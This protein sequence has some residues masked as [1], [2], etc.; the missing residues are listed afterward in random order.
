[1]RRPNTLTRWLR[2]LGSAAG[3]RAAAFPAGHFYSPVVDVGDVASRAA[4]IWPPQPVVQGIDF[5]DGSHRRVLE[6]VFPKFMGDFDYP[7][8]L[9][10]GSAPTQF[11]TA[12]DQFGWLDARALFVLLR[13]WRPRRLIEVG[14]G[15]SSLLIADINRRWFDCAMTFI[16]IE[17]YPPAFLKAPV[18][19]ISRLIASQVQSLSLAEFT[20]LEAGDVL[21]ID[22]SHVSKTGSDVNFLY[23]DVL[24][25]LQPGV[26][27]HIHDVF[28]PHDYPREWV[29]EQKRSWNEQYLVRALLMYSSA[30]RVEFGCA[31]AFHAHRE[32]VAAA[33]GRPLDRAFGGA[34]LWLKKIAQLSV[35]A[36]CMDRPQGRA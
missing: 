34:S 19:G 21:F 12:N 17:P 30:L 15:Y 13:Q 28:L 26:R 31:Y 27:I 20:A 7:E 10:P 16:C 25:H 11:F 1:M 8:Q 4:A 14:S 9:L 29:L 32:R 33:L 2:R 3:S 18:P 23:F 6:E 24:P 22:S 35:R 36:Q 5:D